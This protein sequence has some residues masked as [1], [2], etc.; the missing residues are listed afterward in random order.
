MEKTYFLRHRP[1]RCARYI[2][3]AITARWLQDLQSS[4]NP[5]QVRL[6]LYLISPADL[7][8]GRHISHSYLNE[9][10]RLMEVV[11]DPV[12]SCTSGCCVEVLRR[13]EDGSTRTERVLL[14]IEE[15]VPSPDDPCDLYVCK[16][17]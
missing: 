14:A 6:D 9:L 13:T 5:E 15:H 2:A 3:I 10:A 7:G 12:R 11:L 1:Q 4:R 16:V 17:I 8:H